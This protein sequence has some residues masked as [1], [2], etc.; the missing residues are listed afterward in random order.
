LLAIPW[1]EDVTEQRREVILLQRVLPHPVNRGYQS[2]EDEVVQVV[3][4]IAP[5][6]MKHLAEIVDQAQGRWLRV[7]MQ[8][9][10]LITLDLQEARRAQEEILDAYGIA[11]DRYL[12]DGKQKPRARRRRYR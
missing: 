4:G 1:N 6:D 12:G 9:G 11:A 5:R 10:H 3:N 7:R 8:D 2:W